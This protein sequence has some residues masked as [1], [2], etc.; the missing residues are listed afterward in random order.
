MR[1]KLWLLDLFL[2]IS[3]LIAG[4][5]LRQRQSETYRPRAS[6]VEAGCGGATCSRVARLCLV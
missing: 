5:V 3:V 4:F 6:V 2:L 1:R